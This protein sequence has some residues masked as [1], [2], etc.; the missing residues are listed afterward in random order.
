MTYTKHKTN[1]KMKFIYILIFCFFSLTPC[2]AQT[3][4]NLNQGEIEQKKYS[5]IIKYEKIK[6]KLLVDVVINNKK[7]KFLFDT[8]APFAISQKLFRELEL[9]ETGSVLVEDNSGMAKQL[10]LFSI[11]KLQLGSLIF[12]NTPGIVLQ[13]STSTMLDCFG[14][15]GIIGSNML[16]NSAIQFNDTSNEIIITNN[17]KNLNLRKIAYQKLELS[18]I[19]SSPYFKIEI[20]K[21]D[22]KIFE[23]ILFDSGDD[24]FY[25]MSTKSLDFLNA[26]SNIINILAESKGS[27]VWG[28]HGFNKNETQFVVSLPQI[29]IGGYSFE[30]VIATTNSNESKIGSEILT[31]GKV[32]LDYNKKRFYFEPYPDID[33]GFLSIHPW[34]ISPII[35]NGKL[36]V[37]IIWNKS[38]E[39]QI[40]VGDEIVKF[41]EINYENMTFCDLVKS[42]GNLTSKKAIL[43]IRDIQ[44]KELKTVEIKRL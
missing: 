1:K 32:T 11:S 37:G 15:E 14:I 39:N 31:L 34:E 3:S 27:L 9:A 44:T 6:G 41:N 25:E 21:A 8:G 13:E 18:E 17:V 16:R 29:E 12:L 38:L 4:I 30:N 22:K 2:V 5:E 28:I 35:E 42:K 10:S 20:L 33:I 19:Q 24:G 36:I 26:E 23:K 40:N 7:H 43:I